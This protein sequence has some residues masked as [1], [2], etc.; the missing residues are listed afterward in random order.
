MY[1]CVESTNRR[2]WISYE[3]GYESST[4]T[5]SI[6]PFYVYYRYK[7]HVSERKSPICS[8]GEARAAFVTHTEL[9]IVVHRQAKKWAR[10]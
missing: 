1:V 4:S 9:M 5:R 10:R 2:K 6:D 8:S 3:Q 7:V